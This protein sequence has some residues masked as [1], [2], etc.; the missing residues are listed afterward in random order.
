MIWP[1][2]TGDGYLPKAGECLIPAGAGLADTLALIHQAKSHQRRLT[3]I[4]G[5]TVVQ[6]VGLLD[7]VSA[8]TGS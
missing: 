7:D 8:L 2:C 5:M 6:I 1:N 4:E 3:I